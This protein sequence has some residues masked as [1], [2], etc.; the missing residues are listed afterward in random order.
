MKGKSMLIFLLGMFLMFSCKND[1]KGVQVSL[2]SGKNASIFGDKIDDSN[3][4]SVDEVIAKLQNQDSLT[5]KV[6]GTVTGVCQTKGCWANIVNTGSEGGEEMF[7]QFKDYGFFLPKDCSGKEVVMRG[8]A[9]RETT[10]IDEL[11]HYAEDEGQSAEEIAK[12]TEPVV[13]LKFMA[14]GVLLYE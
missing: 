7:V 11:K 10:T 8:K 9:Y 6:G 13:E 14:D 4:L 5:V 1:P 12:I 3:V 2:E